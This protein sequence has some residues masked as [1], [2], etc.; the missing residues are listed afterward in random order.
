MSDEAGAGR[1]GEAAIERPEIEFL[2]MADFAEAVNGKIYMMGG[3]WDRRGVVDFKQPQGFAVVVGVAI[4]WNDTN[5]PI[6]LAISLLDADGAP[7]LPALQTQLTAGRPPNARPGQ[8]LRFMLAVNLQV[9]LPGLGEY[10]V[11]A[12]VDGRAAKRVG[13]FADPL[14]AM[15]G[16]TLA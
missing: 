8:R 12:Q 4:P 14:Q 6:P 9:I 2:L 5:R 11:E 1:G 7:L 10:V 13:F 15:P 3:G 16:Q